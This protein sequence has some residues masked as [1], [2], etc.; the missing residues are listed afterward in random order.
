M[1]GVRLERFGEVGAR[2]LA[3]LQ[4]NSRDAPFVEQKRALAGVESLRG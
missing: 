4:V 2:K 1:A 3:Q